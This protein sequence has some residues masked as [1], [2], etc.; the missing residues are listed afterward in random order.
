MPT[1]VAR[2][3][4]FSWPSVAFRQQVALDKDRNGDKNTIVRGSFDHKFPQPLYRPED[5]DR[6]CGAHPQKCWSP[7]DLIN[8]EACSSGRRLARRRQR[9]GTSSSASSSTN[10]PDWAG[11]VSAT[12]TNALDCLLDSSVSGGLFRFKLLRFGSAPFWPWLELLCDSNV[13]A[14]SDS[15]S[16]CGIGIWNGGKVLLGCRSSNPCC[17]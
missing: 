7:I 14:V 11:S 5:T 4:A 2:T 12:S 1:S 16:H 8:A 10:R 6:Y 17:G 9:Q 3:P 13:A 15:A